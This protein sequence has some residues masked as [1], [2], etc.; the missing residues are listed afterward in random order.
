MPP[1]YLIRIVRFGQS[2]YTRSKV[3]N[4]Q[5]LNLSAVTSR[6]FLAG[7]LLDYVIARAPLE[8][9]G[10]DY[11]YGPFT[12]VYGSYTI[13]LWCTFFVHNLCKSTI[14]FLAIKGMYKFVDYHL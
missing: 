10:L 12:A 4:H 2:I 5:L 9:E 13:R 7:S 14:F 6:V 1:I 11:Y 3:A 8:R